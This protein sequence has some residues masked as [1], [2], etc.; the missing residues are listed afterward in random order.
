MSYRE[1]YDQI[2][3]EKPRARGF[4]FERLINKIFDDKGILVSP[5]YKTAEN[6]Q[7]IDGAIRLNS[8]I[9][10]LEAKWEKTETLAASKLY[11][12]LGKIN[13]KIEGTLGIFI[14]YNSLSDNFLQ[15]VR[16]GLRQ[17]CIIIHGEKN[18]EDIIDEKVDV[19]EYLTYLFEQVSIKGYVSLD[20]STFHEMPQSGPSTNKANLWEKISRILIDASQG[21]QEMVV[22]LSEGDVN[23][24]ELSSKALNIFPGINKDPT[25]LEKFTEVLTKCTETDEQSVIDEILEKLD[26]KRW[27]KYSSSLLINIFEK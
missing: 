4:A 18:I 10:L 2:K 12:F 1:K 19:A 8:K 17:N 27:E 26:N 23:A 13:S 22:A 16:N 6:A 9:F 15:A 11:S 5:S 25:T 7:Q 20:T 24:E 14:S 21:K 3:N